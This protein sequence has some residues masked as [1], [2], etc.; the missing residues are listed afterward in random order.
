MWSRILVWEL[1]QPSLC[2][3]QLE[4]TKEKDDVVSA[5]KNIHLYLGRQNMYL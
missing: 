2:F 3:K 4:D 5:L 1:R